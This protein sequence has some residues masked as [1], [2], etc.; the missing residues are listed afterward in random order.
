MKK[1]TTLLLLIFTIALSAQSANLQFVEILNDAT[2]YDVK[3]Q[4]QGST[5]FALGS[6]NIKFDYNNTNLST[7]TLGTA[8]NFSGTFY[9]VITVT[10]PVPGITS[11]NIELFVPN[12]GTLVSD[13]GWTD[14]ATIRFTTV[15]SAG[16]SNLVFRDMSPA[17]TNN[18][19]V[20]YLDDETVRLTQGTFTGLNSDPLPVELSSFSATNQKGNAVNLQWETATEVNNYG[21]EVERSLKV[22]ETEETEWEK[23]SFVDGSGNSNSQK[24]Y[25]FLDKNP[26]GGTKFSYRLKQID[27]DGTFEYSNLVEIEVL[28]TE[29]ELYQNY[30]NPF[31]P[32]TKI[33]FS[34]PED[35]KVAVDIYNMLG[36]RVMTLFNK[37]MKAGYHQVL[38]DTQSAGNQLASGVYIYTISTKNFSSVKKMMLLK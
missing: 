29:Y 21:F 19:T 16:S 1:L 28:P 7:P 14:V 6:S 27:I 9:N 4:I 10:E 20:L 23:I 12:L 24:S 11:I 38:F 3:V 36:Q 2:N 22:E 35:A 13:V 25:S 15:N 34:L 30:P 8:H 26:V 17:Q 18:P 31:N 33:K 5:P 37:N 32:S